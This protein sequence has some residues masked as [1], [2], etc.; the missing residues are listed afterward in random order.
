MAEPGSYRV[1]QTGEVV[2][3]PDF[4]ATWTVHQPVSGS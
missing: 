4:I 3:N 2:E 1:R